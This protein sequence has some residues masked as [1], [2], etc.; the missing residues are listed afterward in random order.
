MRTEVL[1]AFIS[2]RYR[3]QSYC[4]PLIEQ[5][6]LKTDKPIDITTEVPEHMTVTAD[7]T[8]LYNMLSNLIG[9]AIKYSGEKTCR[10]ILKGTVSS[11]EMTLSVTDEGIGISE[12]NQKRV[13][14][15]FYRVPSGNLH[16]VKGFGLG[17]Y[18]VSDMMS[19]HNGSVT[20]KSQLG[21]GSTFTLHLKINDNG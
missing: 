12:A 20:V 15:K 21:K 7:R 18:Y 8:H 19:K 3:L 4:H 16:D 5:F 13:F 9:N 14:D 10:I 17:L 11:Q 2:K 6:K 1:S